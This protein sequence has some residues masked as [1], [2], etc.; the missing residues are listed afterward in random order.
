MSLPIF[1]DIPVA[2]P[3][4]YS[5]WFGRPLSIF[6]MKKKVQGLFVSIQCSLKSP[7]KVDIPT[8]QSPTGKYRGLQGN[9]CNETRDPAMRRGV[10][11]NENRFF[12]VRIDS[13]GVP[14][15]LCRVW[16]CSAAQNHSKPQI[17]FGKKSPPQDFNRRTFV[18]T[19]RLSRN[20]YYVM[21]GGAVFLF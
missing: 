17:L 16:V 12:P 15:E 2:L 6:T 13:Q 20:S 21:G 10:S 9:P 1:L 18:Q 19:D 8:L 3:Y 7:K 5:V 14:C 4:L 11:C